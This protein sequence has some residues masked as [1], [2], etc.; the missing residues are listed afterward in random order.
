MCQA[1]GACFQHRRCFPLAAFGH[2]R[3]GKPSR[4]QLVFGLL[5]AANSCPIAIELFAGNTADPTTV[6]SEVARTRSPDFPGERLLV[7]A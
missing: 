2:S 7:S 6:G 4:Q 5:S 3:D 1:S